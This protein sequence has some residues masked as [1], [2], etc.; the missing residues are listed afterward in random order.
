[1][2]RRLLP[3]P[4]R[5]RLPVPR[6]ER[7]REPRG[8]SPADRSA[9][10]R[11]TPLASPERRLGSAAVLGLQRSHGNGHVQRLLAWPIARQP[12]D[13][14][15]AAPK[16]GALDATA[17]AIVD[18]AQNE[19]TPIADRATGAVRAIIR[20]YYG[21]D[22]AKV[23]S[24]KYEASNSG[25]E[26]DSSGKG[27]AI[28]GIITV[29]DYFVKNTNKQGFARRVL[30]VGHELQ[31]IDQWRAGMTGA[32][33]SHQ[34]EFL[35]FYW[36]ATAP[37]RAG[38]GRVSHSTR[39]G[40]IDAALGHLYCLADRTPYA[41]Q[42]KKLLEERKTHETASNKDATPPPSACAG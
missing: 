42:E 10:V 34:R 23:K 28:V 35:A 33:K 12:G 24:V 8:H 11:A 4:T 1:M 26:V 37:A 36:E 3:F 20:D 9:G 32:N 39:V 14:K 17:Q 7:E 2:S 40:L 29:G 21:S 22:A 30:Q 19:K 18:A 6:P 38:T 16:P 27:A 25:L 41:A 15:P 31:H 13:G 5:R